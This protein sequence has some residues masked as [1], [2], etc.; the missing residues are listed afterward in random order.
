LRDSFLI[1]LRMRRSR[2]KKR[3]PPAVV[4]R[5]P[6][7]ICSNCESPIV[8]GIRFCPTCAADWGPPNVRA[9]RDPN[10]REALYKRSEAAF[11]SA[12]LRNCDK[13]LRSL[14]RTIQ[15]ESHVVVALPAL[16]ARL[17]V[18]DPRVIYDNYETLVGAAKRAP[19]SRP[20]DSR[21]ATVG[22]LLFGSSARNIRYGVLSLDGRGLS[23]YG[24]VFFQLRDVAVRRRTSFLESNS[25]RFVAI[26]NL[27]PDSALPR[28]YRC[29]WDDRGHLAAAKLEPR[30]SRNDGPACWPGL[31]LRCDGESRHAD[32]YIEAHIFAGFDCAAIESCTFAES[33]GVSRQDKTDFDVIRHAFK[34]R[35]QSTRGR[36]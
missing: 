15:R 12:K 31:L 22:A 24:N 26:H 18:Q 21:R 25:Y 13:A 19:A 16:A 5:P 32:D 28:G 1:L 9:A 14:T 2:K 8:D 23:T 17:L 10:E 6:P 3:Q 11:A 35:G 30:V 20:D 34:I 29:E 7:S 33:D 36:S 27:R 4:Q